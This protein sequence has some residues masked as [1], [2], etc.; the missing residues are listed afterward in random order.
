M[1]AGVKKDFEHNPGSGSINLINS[2]IGYGTKNYLDEPAMTEAELNLA[3][4]SGKEIVTRIQ[5]EGCN[6]IGFGEMGIGNTS[7]AALIMSAI[8]G[9]PVRDCVGRGTGADD[10]QLKLKIS[11]LEEVFEKHWAEINDG[12]E[13]SNLSVFSHNILRCF[14]GFEIAMMVGALLKAAELRMV[15]VVDGFIATASLLCA[16]LIEPDILKACIFA[17]TSGEQGHQ[18]MLEF[19]GANPLLQFRMRLGEGTGAALVIPLIQSS[20]NFLNEMAS[21][22]SA[23]VSNKDS[24]ELSPS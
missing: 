4:E 13:D 3:I 2:K 12:P 23:G 18:K 9:T 16:K 21:F 10:E 17:H 24:L 22:D 6:I 20:I 7:S 8:T 11:T 15:I 5:S 1:D 19:L 14:G